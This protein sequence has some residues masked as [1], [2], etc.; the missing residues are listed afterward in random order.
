MPGGNGEYK[1]EVWEHG[2]MEVWKN[3]NMNVSRGIGNSRM[4]AWGVKV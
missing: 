1:Y 3:E 2:G 4:E